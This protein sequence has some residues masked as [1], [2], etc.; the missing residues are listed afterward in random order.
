[1][2]KKHPIATN[3]EGMTLIEVMIT[4]G[5]LA[6]IMIAS[7][8]M[9]RANLEMRKGLSEKSLFS[10]RI[11]TAMRMM[12]ADIEHAWILSASI[13]QKQG[14]VRGADPSSIFQFGSAMGGL[15]Q[16]TTAN[17]NALRANAKESD[18]SSVSYELRDSPRFPGR[19]ALFRGAAPRVPANFR[20]AIDMD[21]LA[22]SVKEVKLQAWNGDSY[23]GEWSNQR[24]D[25]LD[26]LPQF[27]KIQIT[28]WND[29]P[30][31]TEEDKALLGDPS[32]LTSYSSTVF[33]PQSLRFKEI[34]DRVKSLNF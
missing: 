29:E 32:F 28:A 27:I 8:T 4:I 2:K 31:Q 11:N 15:L 33:V 9:L 22:D 1:M 20:E 24:S 25:T 12:C 21:L 19:T 18:I 26:K 30:D 34:K 16:L 10:H 3:Q 6:T 5:I 13:D 7:V 23:I 14:R 17:H